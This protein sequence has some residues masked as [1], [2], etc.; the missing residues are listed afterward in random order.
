VR[1][2]LTKRVVDH[3]PG[4]SDVSLFHGT[5]DK[6]N[7]ASLKTKVDLSFI[8]LGDFHDVDA[9]GVDGGFYLTDSLLP[10]AQFACRKAL[11]TAGSEEKVYVLEFKWSGAS[12]PVKD[13]KDD[14][15]LQKFLDYDKSSDNT[16]RDPAM[17]AIMKDNAMITGPMKS[18]TGADALLTK[19]F[20]QYA[21]IKQNAADNQLKYVTTHEVI[22]SAVPIDEDLNEAVYT[23]GQRSNADF[24][25]LQQYAER[26]PGPNDW[27][28]AVDD[29]NKKHAGQ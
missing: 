27:K 25:K 2:G 20:W 28:K 21:V 19:D 29:Y 15:E 26:C 11:S 23:T 22:C 18:D 1:R 9:D 17:D 14:A 6:T 8:N 7:A 10:A 24:D 3:P 13:F 16:N 5:E 12:L 4:K